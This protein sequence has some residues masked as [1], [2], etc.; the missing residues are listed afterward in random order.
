MLRLLIVDDEKTTRES[1]ERYIPW[2]TLKVGAVCTA[3]G[4]AEALAIAQA[5]PPDILLT[6]VRMPRMDG[7][8]LAQ[9]FRDLYPFCKI[10]FLS[11]FADKDYLKTAIRLQAVSYIEKPIDPGEVAEVVRIAVAAHETE[12]A[13]RAETERL[14][15]AQRDTA[16]LVRE[17][18]IRRLVQG[19]ATL[20]E[21]RAAFTDS[22]PAFEPGT[23][24]TAATAVLRW[25]RSVTEADKPLIRHR[26][27]LACGSLGLFS[28][29]SAF[30]GFVEDD[31]LA[32]VVARKVLEPTARSTYRELI[33]TLRAVC[34]GNVSVTIGVGAPV[35][36]WQGIPGS[37]AAALAAARLSFYGDGNAL[38]FSADRPE[39]SFALERDILARIG[40][41]I[42]DGDVE[43][44]RACVRRIA[45]EIARDKPSDI[46]SVRNAFFQIHQCIREALQV[47][48]PVA[49][50]RGTTYIWEEI[51]RSSGLDELTGLLDSLLDSASECRSEQETHPRRILSIQRHVRTS[52]ADPNLT[53]QG[54]AERAGLSRTY[55]SALFKAVTGTNLTEYITQIRIDRAKELLRAGT[56][57]TNEISSRVGYQ[58]ANYFSA[59]FKK[60]VGCTPTEFRDSVPR[61]RP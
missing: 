22:L 11:G 46:D 14:R 17:Q 4:G 28:T 39:S 34:A 51:R 25:D 45:D 2:T 29:P 37:H 36:G 42:R 16:C 61:T 18:I 56:L 44:A 38:L 19:S 55:L 41:C 48:E 15:L 6:D 8:H 7:L 13:A 5:T 24:F 60:H 40:A 31:V 43:E 49:L 50:Q 52:F 58:D 30:L 53:L 26:M 35:C 10:V 32:I 12:A 23:A 9:R 47:D 57:R 1:L 27:L 33:D 21:L 59:L 20:S 54:I 3:R